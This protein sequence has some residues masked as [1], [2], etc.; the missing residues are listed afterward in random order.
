MKRKCVPVGTEAMLWSK[1]VAPPSTP[2][3]R[4]SADAA[5]VPSPGSDRSTLPQCF[6][7]SERPT[8]Q[9]EMEVLKCPLNVR[10]S[11]VGFAMRPQL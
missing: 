5:T 3:L 7:N 9:L 6:P 1:G 4:C 10:S 2:F 11:R 8:S